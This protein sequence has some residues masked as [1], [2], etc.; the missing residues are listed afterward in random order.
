MK[1][2]AGYIGAALLAALA[3]A[4]LALGGEPPQPSLATA[5]PRLAAIFVGELS[6]STRPVRALAF[7]PDGTMLAS[8]GVDGVVRLTALADRRT[9][10]LFDHPG[11]ATALA[12][13]IDGSAIATA[14]YDGAVRLWRLSAGAVRI[15]HPSTAPI[16]TLAFDPAGTRLAAAGED[17]RIHLWP[18]D[19]SGP[20]RV[21]AGHSLN[22][23]HIAFSSDGRTIASGSFD[24]TLKLWDVA[25]G[26]LLRSVTGHTE[27]IVGLDV[28]KR[29][30]LIATGGD[31][32]TIRLWRR[33][34]VPL[35]TIAAGQFVDTV[36]FSSDGEW[37]A[38]GGRESHGRNAVFKELLG[39][40]P[41]G[42][43]GV[44]ARIWR[45]RDGAMVAAFDRQEDDV[46]AVAISPDG[47]WFA[48]GSDDGSVALWRLTRVG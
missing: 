42:G 46:V 40:R 18:I 7:S 48:S 14:G 45:V 22:I 20:G 16:W 39:R 29:D 19:D 10:H 13:A 5:G 15:F 2:I 3:L 37:L 33:D 34:G 23:W 11:G 4:V 9:R 25:S 27:G 28:R 30:G 24:R 6:R 21:F 35:R 26:H 47:T 43:H 31:D 32:G 36:A 8:T 1:R 38:A 41:D 12:F 17:K 44:S